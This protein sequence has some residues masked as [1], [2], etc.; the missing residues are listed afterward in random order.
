M[1]V[2]VAALFS[3]SG[4][5]E[6]E[7]T[8]FSGDDDREDI[9]KAI[10][11]QNT[12]LVR[13]TNAERGRQDFGR[14]SARKLTILVPR[15]LDC[16]WRGN[17]SPGNNALGINHCSLTSSMSRKYNVKFHILHPR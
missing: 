17:G 13:S 11:A 16:D 10:Q 14:V 4:M 3:R 7:K 2:V 6:D 8:L 12:S 15:E 1:L 9:E 5:I